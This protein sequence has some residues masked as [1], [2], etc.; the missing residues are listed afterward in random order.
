MPFSIEDKHTIKVLR[1]QKL[2]GATKILRMFPNKNWTLSGVKTVL[3]KIGASGSVERC[4]GSGRPHTARSPD[5]ISDVQDLV[6][7]GSEP[8]RQ[9]G[10][11]NPTK[12]VCTS[13]NGSRTWNSCQ[14]VEEEWGH[15]DQE[16]IDN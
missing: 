7:S 9:C 15:P 6:L 1:E 4:S 5:T 11:E 10:V 8:R 12:S 14:R 3:S 13:I 16:V 2:Y